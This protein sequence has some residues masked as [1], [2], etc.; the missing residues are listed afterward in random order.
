MSS[1][2]GFRTSEIRPR[3]DVFGLDGVRLGT[4]T[5]VVPGSVQ[6]PSAGTDLSGT[7]G[8]R[9]FDGEATGP[10]PTRSVGNFGPETQAPERRYGANVTAG[11]PLGAGEIEIGTVFGMF[12]RR[13]IPLDE[14]QTVSLER[15]VLRKRASEY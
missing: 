2:T 6:A 4:I 5:K 13:R 8:V 14:V 9:T 3:M 11:E 15:V 7:E 10:A 12:W 1:E